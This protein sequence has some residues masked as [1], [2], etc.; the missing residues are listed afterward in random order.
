MP[1]TSLALFLTAVVA[2]FARR[3]HWSQGTY[4]KRTPPFVS[5]LP[6]THRLSSGACAIRLPWKPI[7]MVEIAG[8]YV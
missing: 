4:N 6:T 7:R 8:V 1:V 5:P 3:T 2:L